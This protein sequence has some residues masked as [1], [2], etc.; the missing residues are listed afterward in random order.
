[1][2]KIFKI[3][4]DVFRIMLDLRLLFMVAK[5]F[6]PGINFSMLYYYIPFVASNY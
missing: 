6:F 2:Y 1:M 5:F 4:K 3:L